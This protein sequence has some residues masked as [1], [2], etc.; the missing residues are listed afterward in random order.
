MSNQNDG[1]DCIK[2]ATGLLIIEVRGSNPNGDPDRESDPRQRYDDRGEISPVSFKRKV[3]DLVENKEGPVWQEI[4]K[5]FKPKLE[6]AKF[7]ILESRG[8]DRKAIENEIK[9]GT[10]KEK[11]WD[12]RVFGNT[13]LEEGSST[14][15]RT[16]VVQFGLGISIAPIEIERMT[17]T[18]KAGVQEDK[19]R[20]MAPLGYRIVSH[21]VYC[22]PFFVNPTAATATS[23]TNTD[24][25]LLKRI[26][27]Y[28]YS[29]TASY[30]RSFVGI[31]HAW[32]IEHKSQLG[33][34]SD[35]KL[36]DALTPKKKENFDPEKPSKTWD[37]YD[38]PTKLP[39]DLKS[40]VKP[41]LDLMDM[42]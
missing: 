1:N 35:F 7:H 39:E 19:D 36:I 32:Y 16:G 25:E 8:R 21:G 11:Y 24:I 2:K 26:L 33:S 30:I 14:S 38:F 3:R 15:I 6:D 13:F 5:M 22:M 4:S 28:A 29:H 34:C 20:G 42:Q 9:D 10:F 17:T 12:G 23:C 31:R 41:L 40:K 27:P 18:N 37:E